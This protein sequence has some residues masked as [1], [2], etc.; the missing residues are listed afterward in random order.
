MRS[1]IFSCENLVLLPNQ[2]F[3]KIHPKY[4]NETN[5]AD[6]FKAARN[7]FQ[8]TEKVLQGRELYCR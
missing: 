5:I 8:L 2:I 3:T 7:P 6:H 1:D 4:F